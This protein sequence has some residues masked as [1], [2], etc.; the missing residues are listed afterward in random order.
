MPNLRV[1]FFVSAV[2]LFYFWMCE[3]C[4]AAVVFVVVKLVHSLLIVVQ[5]YVVVFKCLP[6]FTICTFKTVL[7]EAIILIFYAIKIV[8]IYK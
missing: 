8:C 7:R 5:T 1:L 3:M 2:H 6:L 4:E